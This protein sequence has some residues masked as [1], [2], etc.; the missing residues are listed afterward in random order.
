MTV[1][2]LAQWGGQ[3]AGTLYTTDAVTEAAMVTA[4][5]ASSNLTLGVAWVAPGNSASQGAGV[6]TPAQVAQAV[7]QQSPALTMLSFIRSGFVLPSSGPLLSNI[8]SGDAVINGVRILTAALPVWFPPSQDTYVDI[9]QAGVAVLVSVANG[10]TTG[11]A[12][13]PNSLRIGKV[14]TGASAIT[15]STTR[16]M[17]PQANCMGNTSP[18]PGFVLGYATTQNFNGASAAVIFGVGSTIFDNSNHHSEGINNTR[19]TIQ[20]AGIYALTGGVSTASGGAGLDAVAFFK[21][22]T[23]LPN[24]F[25]QNTLQQTGSHAYSIS[26]HALLSPGE[27]IELNYNPTTNN[28]TLNNAWLSCFRIG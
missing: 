4:G 15:S 6:L 25:P 1:A 24:L 10:A 13:T 21:S 19:G 3:P 14:V 16:A 22:G 5:V 20:Q 27:Y 11:M 12:V 7:A 23:A 8:G 28:I 26:A 18:M 9:T 17:D 2:L